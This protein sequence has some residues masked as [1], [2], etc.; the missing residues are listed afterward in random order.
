MSHCKFE[1]PRHGSLAFLPR[2]RTKKHRGKLRSFPRDDRSKPTHLTAFMGYKAGMTHV[3]RDVDRPGSKLHKKESVEA[4]TIIEVPPMVAVGVVG[5]VETPRGLRALTS[6]WAEHLSEEMLRRFYK[7]WYQSKHKAFTKYQQKY[8]KE[9]RKPVEEDL[10]R[11]K[12]YA[13]V[14][15]VIM[16]TQ[17][18][19]LNFRQK[20]AHV[21]EVQVNGGTVAEKVDFAVKLFEQQVRVGWGW[22]RGRARLRARPGEREA[23][24]TRGGACAERLAGR[25]HTSSSPPPPPSRS[26]SPPSLR[27]ARRSTLRA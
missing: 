16:H 7:N 12:K 22:E 5:Y 15:R 21:L 18:K 14:V 8:T 6:V 9:G 2:K 10:A 25:Q 3:L 26:P 23:E 24:L 19:K 27:R 1:H 11:I 4:V 20:K 17:I 13:Q